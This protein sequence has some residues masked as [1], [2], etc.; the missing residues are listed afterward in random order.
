MGTMYTENSC[1]LRIHV[2]LRL[3]VNLKYAHSL[4]PKFYSL[5]W[6]PLLSWGDRGFTHMGLLHTESYTTLI[7]YSRA[8][9]LGSATNVSHA[10]GTHS[11]PPWPCKDLLCHAEPF[12]IGIERWTQNY[13]SLHAN[14]NTNTILHCWR[15]RRAPVVLILVAGLLLIALFYEPL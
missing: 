12:W 15:K 6:V 11:S 2:D 14:G 1:W 7:S 8:P 4:P 10:C 9:L 13:P 5:K 3:W